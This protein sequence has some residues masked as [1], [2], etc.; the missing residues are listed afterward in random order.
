MDSSKVKRTKNRA[1]KLTSGLMKNITRNRYILPTLVLTA[2][3]LITYLNWDFADTARKNELQ[4]YFE[5]RARDVSERIEQRVIGYKQILKATQGLFNASSEVNREE[6][7]S[8]FNSLNLDL[9]YPGIQGVGFSLI[10]PSAQIKKHVTSIHKE[11]FSGYKLWPEGI[12]ETYTSIIYLEPFK[13]L[14]LRA[15]GYDMYSEPVRR[16][17][18]E[19]AR[20]SNKTVVSGK[21]NLVQETG[22]ETQAGFLI[23]LPVY[24]KGTPQTTLKD[25]RKNII[26]WV[27]SP[28]RMR[29]FME[30]IFGERGEDLDVEI[31]DGEHISD[32][33]KMYSSKTHKLKL[34]N[35]LTIEKV[36]DFN[37]HEWR[38]LVTYTPL[39]ESRLGF[40]TARII[41]FVGLSLSILL[42]IITYLLINNKILTA[43]ANA[44]LKLAGD[45]LKNLQKD[46]QILLDN[47]P[48]WVFFKDT[49]NRFIRVNKTFA[50][51]MGMPAEQLEGK[52]LFDIFPKEQAEAFWEDDKEV[53]G[54]GTS[55]NKIIEAMESP[56]GKIWVQTDKIPY[57]DAHGKVVGLIGFAL[58]ITDR[59][60]AEE[61]L[62]ESHQIIE[63]IIN[64]IPV[65][66]F[67]KDTNL[68]FLGCNKLFAQDA[69]FTDP[70]EIIGKNDFQMNWGKQAEQYQQDDR[71]VIES[72]RPKLNIEE[73]QTTP[74]G[75]L[76]TLLTSKIPLLNSAGKTIGVLGTYVDISERKYAEVE[77]KKSYEQVTKINAEKD[78]FFSI[79]A[80][81]LRS[82]FNGFIGLTGLMADKSEKFSKAEFVE[83]S[84]SL[85]KAAKNLYKLLENLLEWSQIQKGTIEFT[86]KNLQLSKLV[87]ESI[88]TIYERALQ[89]RITIIREIDNKQKVF[90]DEKMIGTVLR[91]L[92][93]NAI[94]FTR[95]DGKVSIKSEYLNNG[96][97]KISV[98]D[99]GIG[100]HEEDVKRLFKIEEKVSTLGTDGEISSGLGLLLCK[101]FIEMHGEK[102]WVE[103]KENEGSKFSF[104]LKGENS[105]EN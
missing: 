71:E 73:S 103:S 105:Y 14:N 101:E 68:V 86:P 45:S 2:C 23:Y 83:Q 78:K 20:D 7:S 49:A 55:K 22:S 47:I 26:G 82:P 57:I 50:D 70:K 46:Q 88:D 53:I 30:G 8:F 62:L 100:M 13:D 76:I 81:D 85:N 95:V 64:S 16:R 19:T 90:A 24:K 61:S 54:S 89:K 11:G 31:Y 92:L 28:F 1:G 43:N 32:E 39:L 63:G 67:W 33:T 48:A 84:K 104:T 75:N 69:G 58:D 72:G 17:A 44:E 80:H 42:T 9:N 29:N 40:S 93:S 91:N 25:R 10:I 6:F 36:L 79:I 59:K 4:S 97:I 99:N 77:L 65:R 87:S 41:L 60:H 5:Y 15:F 3:L 12:R 38:V 96:T 52:S 94:K 27:Y 34:N 102:I 37:E 66:V 21:V 51:V 74:D 18:M 56:N 35:P 98:E